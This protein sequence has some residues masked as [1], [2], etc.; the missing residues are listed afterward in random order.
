MMEKTQPFAVSENEP[1]PDSIYDLDELERETQRMATLLE[2]LL[3]RYDPAGG[4]VGNKELVRAWR[5]LYE[6]W[7]QAERI[8]ESL[9]AASRPPGQAWRQY[10]ALWQFCMRA[11]PARSEHEWVEKVAEWDAD[12]E[13]IQKVN[14][15]VRTHGRI[16]AE[17]TP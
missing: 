15:W 3:Q 11:A 10:M 17:T 2:S 4:L 16:P 13:S 1:A 6:L 8:D 7:N 5:R 9:N 14:A 12:H